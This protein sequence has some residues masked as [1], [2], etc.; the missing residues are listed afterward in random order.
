[1]PEVKEPHFFSTDFHEETDRFYDRSV[2]RRREFKYR[3]LEEYMELFKNMNGQKAVGEAS[4]DYLFSDVAAQNIYDFNPEAKIII[5]IRNPIEFIRSWFQWNKYVLLAENAENIQEALELEEKRK[6]GSTEKIKHPPPSH[7]LYRELAKYYTHIQKF[8]KL[9]PSGNIKIILF[10]DFVSD[11]LKI[12]QQLYEF[13]DVDTNF[14]PE[15]KSVNESAIPKHTI[16]RFLMDLKFIK[17]I[18]ENVQQ[19]LDAKRFKRFKKIYDKF[20]YSD[21]EKI[22]ISDELQ[23]EI[24]DNIRDN[25]IQLNKLLRQH[26]LVPAGTDLLKLWNFEVTEQD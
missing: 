6:Q 3:E 21:N 9:F 11:N 4:V 16:L 8:V 14:V 20:I 1:M 26:E 12:S 15:L 24:R 17:W 7:L 22:D 18:R 2:L 25:I 23:T 5:S 19:K 13:L 10:D